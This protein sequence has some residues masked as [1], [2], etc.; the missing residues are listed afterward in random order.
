MSMKKQILALAFWTAAAAPAAIVSFTDR[1]AFLGAATG[2]STFDFQVPTAPAAINEVGGGQVGLST[3]G[4]ANAVSLQVYG[5]TQAI[6][7]RTALG[8]LNNFLPLLLTFTVPVTAFGFDNLDL[9]GGTTEFAI[10]TVNFADATPAQVFTFSGGAPQEAVFFGLTSTSAIASVQIYSGDTAASA[11]GARGNLIDNLVIGTAAP[12]P[13]PTGVP[14]P[15]A[16]VTALSGIGLVMVGR[17][18][19]R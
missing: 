11:P 7:G 1:A 19:R 15:G 3:V 18:K 17:L 2:T 5:A 10:V 6:G 4:G 13:P 14:E 16:W 12:D 9:T 8:E